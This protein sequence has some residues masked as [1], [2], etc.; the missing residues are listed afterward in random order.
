LTDEEL[1]NILE[2]LDEDLDCSSESDLG[3]GDCDPKF[4]ENPNV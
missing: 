3:E 1:V 2:N 4:N